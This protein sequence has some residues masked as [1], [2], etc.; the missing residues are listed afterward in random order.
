MLPITH[1]QPPI[2]PLTYDIRN[3]AQQPQRRGVKKHD[4]ERRTHDIWNKYVLFTSE[5]SDEIKFTYILF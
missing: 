2:C 5:I 4:D 3:V 1:T